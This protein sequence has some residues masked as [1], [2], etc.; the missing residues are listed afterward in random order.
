LAWVQ[1]IGAQGDAVT[2]LT[3]AAITTTAGNCI[4]FGAG[5]TAGSVAPATVTDSQSDPLTQAANSP[6]G[7]GSVNQYMYSSP[8]IAGG[9]T[10]F[11][12][13]TA[14]STYIN[15]NVGEFS[16]RASSAVEDTSANQVDAAVVTSHPGPTFSPVAGSDAFYA[17]VNTSS[18]GTETPTP[19]GGWTLGTD[20]TDGAGGTAGHSQ[21]LAN[22]AGGSQ[23][24]PYT[25]STSNKAT[26]VVI[27]LKAAT[28]AAPLLEPIFWHANMNPILAQ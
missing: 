16:G 6:G 8:G 1:A 15:I 18:S 24:C 26:G 14:A 12:V 21:Y 2:S 4:A 20:Q 27:A 5:L 7:A 22:V 13:T 23:G 9:S 25:S 11:K 17:E 28:V 10:T 3:T 19:T